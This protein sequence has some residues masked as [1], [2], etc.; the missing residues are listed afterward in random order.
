MNQINRMVTEAR[1]AE[2]NSKKMAGL[3]NVKK[4][5]SEIE[6][7]IKKMRKILFDDLSYMS[8]ALLQK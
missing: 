8:L 4:T 7:C 3:F 6:I 1:K 2:I 5:T